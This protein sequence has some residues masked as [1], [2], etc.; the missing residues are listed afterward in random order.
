MLR[1]SWCHIIHIVTGNQPIQSNEEVLLTY[2]FGGTFPFNYNF[3]T[4]TVDD[5]LFK[6]GGL[7]IFQTM[8]CIMLGG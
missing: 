8:T 3:N 4:H 6:A 1:G 5:S 7:N 2:D